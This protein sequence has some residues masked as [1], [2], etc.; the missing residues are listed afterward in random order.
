VTECRERALPQAVRDLEDAVRKL[1]SPQHRY[2][3]D[4]LRTAPSRYHQL[5]AEIAGTQGENHAPPKSM[6]PLWLKA[7]QLIA[8]IDRQARRWAPRPYDTT[9]RLQ[10]IAEQSWRPQDTDHVHYISI[11]VTKWCNS[12]DALL[13][14]VSVKDVAAPCPACGTTHIYRMKDGERV[15]QAA[16]QIITETG[17]TCQA[18][19]TH[20]GPE[21]Y[22]HLA[23]V[24][25]FDT[26]PG[27]LE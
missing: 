13:E 26:L 1:T 22:L 5:C 14:P 23:R 16:L 10:H 3:G 27:V 18:C 15:R 6:P 11:T 8:D 7:A 12:I 2:F 20:W 17:C 25:G 21:L 24:I 19:D 9:S 4:T